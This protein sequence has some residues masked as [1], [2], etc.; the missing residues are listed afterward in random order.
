MSPFPSPRLLPALALVPLLAGPALPSLVGSPSPPA[1]APPAAEVAPAAA[2]VAPAAPDADQEVRLEL[3]AEEGETATYR[4]ETRASITPPPA[5]GA[6]TEVTSTMVLHRTVESVTPDSLRFRA[7]VEDFQLDVSSQDQRARGQLE[8]MAERARENA[9]GSRFWLTVSPAGEMIRMRREG[10]ATVEG[11]GVEQSLRQLS[12]AALPRGPVG[13][14]DSWSGTDS[15]DA[16][17]FGAPVQGTVVTDTRTTLESIDRSGGG[18]V[19]VLQ[20][21]GTFELHPDTASG[22]GITGEMEGSSAQT[23]R[24]DIEAGRFLD[25][26]GAQDVTFN[27]SMPGAQGGSLSVQT[28]IRH[29]SRLVDG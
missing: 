26:E 28:T 4:Y 15:L 14:G 17:S 12:F 1:G 22:G 25:A 8:S 29:S 9:V 5:L 19:A 23:L 10:G 27:L 2:N 13:V 16:S 7:R 3:K 11:S 20:V 6:A 18:P 21:E 24:F